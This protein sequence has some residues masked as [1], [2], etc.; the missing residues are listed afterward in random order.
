MSRWILQISAGVGPA[1][2]RRFVAKLATQLVG[3]CEALCLGVA[4]VAIHGD[5]AAPGSVEIELCGDAPM[6]LADVLGTHVLIARSGSRGRRSRKR[7]FAGVSLHRALEHPV[8]GLALRSCDLEISTMR[9]GGPGGQHVNTTDSAVRVRHK[10]SGVSVRVASERS[11]HMNKRRALEQLRSILMGREQASAKAR[12]RDLRVSHYQFER[13]SAV[14]QWA[15]DERTDE[16]RP[17]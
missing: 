14:R 11:Q 6:L 4:S 3:A 5:E 16:L 1:E 8:S 10:A 13:G 2:V 15:L 7:W 17:V 12:G 9:A